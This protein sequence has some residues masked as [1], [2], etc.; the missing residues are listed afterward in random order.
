MSSSA[1]LPRAIPGCKVY[2][3]LL[4]APKL[5]HPSENAI[6]TRRIEKCKTQDYA[7]T[8]INDL[9]LFVAAIVVR[10]ANTALAQ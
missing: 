7:Q 10:M 1:W 8:Q 5:I 6:A 4:Y 2:M 9:P 3:F